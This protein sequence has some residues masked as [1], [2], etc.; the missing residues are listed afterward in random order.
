MR[1]IIIFS[2]LFLC[3]MSA[4]I[5]SNYEQYVK[6]EILNKTTTNPTTIYST[7]KFISTNKMNIVDEA[8][9]SS[10]KIDNFVK[11][12]KIIIPSILGLIIFL[13]TVLFYIIKFYK[14]N[15]TF[16]WS[17]IKPKTPEEYQRRHQS[18]QEQQ[19]ALTQL[20][21]HLQETSQTIYSVT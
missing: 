11:S 14:N 17:W 18:S 12:C 16:K 10:N 21:R 1:S 13:Y 6:Y 3:G 19:I 9:H 15:C 7:K 4:P 20:I 2:A 5:Y 8:E